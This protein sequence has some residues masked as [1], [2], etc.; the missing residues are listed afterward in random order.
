LLVRVEDGAEVLAH[1]PAGAS[2]TALA[3]S[4]TGN[5]LAIGAEDGEAGIIDLA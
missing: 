3:W 4:A 2:I 5:L 1:R